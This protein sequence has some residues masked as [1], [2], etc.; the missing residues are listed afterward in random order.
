MTDKINVMEI[1]ERKTRADLIVNC[2]SSPDKTSLLTALKIYRQT[3]NE[4]HGAIGDI[5][6]PGAK[7]AVERIENALD[8]TIWSNDDEI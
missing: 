8:Q 6:E 7:Y 1:E 4:V 3:L 5:D 2:D